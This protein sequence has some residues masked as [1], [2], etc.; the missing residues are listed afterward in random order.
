MKPR[1]NERR[2]AW[3]QIAILAVAIS[4]VCAAP[5]LAQTCEDRNPPHAVALLR[6]LQSYCENYD[7]PYSFDLYGLA[8]V[9]GDEAIP[10]LRKIAIWPTDTPTGIYCQRWVS[11]ARVALAKLGDKKSREALDQWLQDPKRQ[12][13]PIGELAI[14]GDDGALRTLIEYLVAHANDPAMY[15]DFATTDR[16]PAIGCCRRSIR[17]AAAD[18][19]P[20]CLSRTTPLLESRN[21]KIIWPDTRTCSLRFRF[22]PMFR[23]RT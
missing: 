3:L 7:V 14:V 11:A 15:R 22:I 13:P 12:Y 4:A 9:A 23:T 17:F 1:S 6:R 21:G 20:D 5:A 16:T 10:A 19:C 18:A 8:A 2:C